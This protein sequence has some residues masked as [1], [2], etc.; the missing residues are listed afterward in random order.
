MS[1][2]QADVA[3]LYVATFN[4]AP[5]AE[6]LRYW[7]NDSGLS[8]EGI[9]QS[10]FDQSETQALY[11]GGTSNN[12]FV[13]SVY[14]N[15]FNRT[16]DDDGFNYWVSELDSGHV[17]KQTFILAV[18]NG[19]QNT[20]FGQDITILANKQTI[21][22]DF[23]ATGLDDVFFAK[24]VMAK[25]DATNES[26]NDALAQ[27]DKYAAPVGD[28][29]EEMV[30][31][32]TLY[33]YNIEDNYQNFSKGYDY[34]FNATF[35]AD[36]T[37]L[38]N[39]YTAAFGSSNW[40][41]EDSNNNTTWILVDGRLLLQGSWGDGG[42]SYIWNDTVTLLSQT[43]TEIKL[44]FQGTDTNT[45]GTSTTDDDVI[46][47]LSAYA[48]NFLTQPP[49]RTEAQILEAGWFKE[50][51]SGQVNFLDKT[52]A[53]VAVPQDAK[54]VITA[55]KNYDQGRIILDIQDDGSFSGIQYF[56]FDFSSSSNIEYMVLHDTNNNSRFD[57]GEDLYASQPTI[58]FVG[59]PAPFSVIIS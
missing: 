38:E 53:P 8:I 19:A 29:T 31:G 26:V 30:S 44:Y 51:F 39:N 37:V 2:T 17:S 6:G 42:D 55:D 54:V 20:D 11:P 43:A 50:T 47:N 28:F 23:V 46:V 48:T 5:D 36:G 18:I 35:N 59:I 13:T 57:Y 45:R 21:G 41:L 1:V 58:D 49:V 52:E 9:A 24:A 10:F 14:A 27:I 3:K 22:L 34:L 4:R 16:P 32:L 7:T 15:L 33:Q 56:A 25:I 12:S 40:T